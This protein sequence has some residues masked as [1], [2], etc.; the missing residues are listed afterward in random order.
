MTST[1]AALVLLAL[2]L[3]VKCY[4]VERNVRDYGAR[5]DG[6]TDDSDAIIRA[7]TE[8]RGDNPRAVFP[9]AN[10]P[11]TTARAAY[12]FFPA[13]TY[14]VTK[15]LPVVYY[16]QMVGDQDSPPTIKFVHHGDTEVRVI[17]SMGDWYKDACQ[18]NFYKMVRNFVFDVTDCK[19]CT[20]IHWR[21]AQATSLTNI[22]FKMGRGSNSQGLWMEDGSGGF[23]SDLVFEG[24]KFGMWIGNQQF[25]NRNITIRDASVAAVFL[26]WDWVWTFHNFFISNCPV[27]FDVAGSGGYNPSGTGSL[28][29]LDSKFS[30]VGI[31]VNTHFDR[32]S[33]MNTVVLDNVQV[34]PAGVIVKNNQ[35]VSLTGSNVGLWAQGRIWKNNKGE[36]DIVDL[37]KSV[38]SRPKMLTDGGSY[39]FTKQRPNFRQSELV[40]VVRELGFQIG[41]DITQKLQAALRQYAY[42][43]VLYFPHGIYKISDTVVVPPGTRILGQAWS[44]FMADGANFQNPKSPI[45]MIQVGN[46]NERGQAQIVDILFS[47][48]G[49]QPG[50]KLL[51]WNM[52]DKDG[53]MGSNGMWDTH[54]RIGGGVGTDIH[55]GNCLRGD[56]STAPV[57][58]CTGAWGLMH[59]TSTGGLYMENVWAWTADHDID[60]AQQINVYNARGIL[61][62]SKGP[63][64]MYG[65]AS[66]HNLLY[67][68]NFHNASNIV[69]GM[70]QTET[71]YFQ[72]SRKTP[73]DRTDARDPEFCQGSDER[74]RMS[75][76]V[77]IYKSNNLYFYGTGLYSFFNT[78]SQDCLRSAGGPNCQ[79][80][81]VKVRDS[82]Q[83]YMHAVNTYGSVYMKTQQEEYSMA[84]YQNNTFCA[85]AAIDLNH[86]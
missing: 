78:W 32:L 64:W 14:L 75:L 58:Q 51:V 69:L 61:V 55:S 33:S 15:T 37:S 26:N 34:Q 57:N 86:F 29:V 4:Q 77:N 12:V 46:P 67:Q 44:V 50:A 47:T 74:C 28:V 76:A 56:G 1:L 5:G 39:Y 82:K 24:G 71:P 65:T 52:K 18:N 38:A 10:Y 35:E 70:I 79:L 62:E 36:F 43:K 63:L 53:E 13:G 16:T 48:R 23:F 83:V 68:Y 42:K 85:T 49:P 30:N 20:V 9:N 72:P 84:K 59:I 27:G 40:N 3:V 21:V 66:E 6:V 31:P 80:E 8:E 73:F 25:G 2:I 17:E 11:A 41:S 81:M 19:I 54:F 7:L 22:H 45:P 60:E